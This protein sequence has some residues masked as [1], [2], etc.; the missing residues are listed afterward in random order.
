M[1]KRSLTTLTVIAVVV[2]GLSVALLVNIIMLMDGSPIQ[3]LSDSADYQG[4]VQD[5]TIINAVS[6][7]TV[8]ITEKTVDTQ[9]E[10]Q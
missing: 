3:S 1:V 2:A 9:V 10:V 4:I 7:T 5:E 8:E 6:E